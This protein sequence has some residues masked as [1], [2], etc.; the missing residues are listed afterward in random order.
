MNVF[1]GKK[2][3]GECDSQKQRDD[4][5]RRPQPPF[6]PFNAPEVGAKNFGASD[7]WVTNRLCFTPQQASPLLNQPARIHFRVLGLKVTLLYADRPIPS[8]RSCTPEA[9]I[10]CWSSRD[11]R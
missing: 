8:G 11:L 2:E 10:S 7:L 6:A 9:R 4:K 3:R 5:G 1:A